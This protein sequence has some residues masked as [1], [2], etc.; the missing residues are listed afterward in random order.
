MVYIVMGVSGC[1]KTTVGEALAERLGLEFYDADAFHPDENRR[2]MSAG[3][4]LTDMDRRPWLE[5]LAG[6]IKKWNGAGGAVLACSALK[7]RY[8]N[9]LSQHGGVTY[10]YLKGNRDLIAHRLEE[11]AGH[12]FPAGLLDSQ[13]ATLEPPR[14]A[15]VV[16][17]DPPINTQIDHI[18]NAI[19]GA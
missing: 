17:I 3:T 7:Q 12:F 15:V 6:A 14:D 9:T 8:R 1:G 19:G 5:T 13:L 18:V 11:R 16:P 10:I 2:K 4:P